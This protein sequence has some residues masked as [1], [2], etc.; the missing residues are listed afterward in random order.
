MNSNNIWIV[1]LLSIAVSST[2]FAG[3]DWE[4]IHQAEAHKISR[5]HA[6]MNVKK[7][8]VFLDHGPRAITTP[9]LEQE[10]KLELEQRLQRKSL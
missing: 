9:Y 4:I 5:E 6:L 3:P 2:A 10:R 7:K 8:S 1:G